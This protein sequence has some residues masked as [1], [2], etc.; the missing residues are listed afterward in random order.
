MKFLARLL[1]SGCFVLAAHASQEQNYEVVEG[2]RIFN[3]RWVFPFLSGGSWGRGPHSNGESC[4]D[5]HFAG[6]NALANH[7]ANNLPPA[8]L[9]IGI[10]DGEQIRPHDIY[11]NEISSKGVIGKLT[12]EG[13][14]LI[15]WST[16]TMNGQS[17]QKPTPRVTDL[18]FGDLAPNVE[19]SLRL[20]RKLVGL[21]LFE[22]VSEQQLLDIIDQQKSS[23]I[24][25]RI[26]YVIDPVTR[27]KK[28][29]RL[30]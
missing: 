8:V 3:A 4:A 24:T 28:I 15:E 10:F 20:G 9:R 30:A 27:E 2:E 5:C 7:S 18:A 14:V 11:G 19:Q 12:A 1:L 29:G 22:K 23:G 6:T 25:G 21:G 16:V 17:L 13:N 26:N